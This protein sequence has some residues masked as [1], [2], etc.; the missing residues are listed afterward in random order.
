MS[1][2]VKINI[3]S[4]ED[5]GAQRRAFGRTTPEYPQLFAELFHAAGTPQTA[6]FDAKHGE[7]PQAKAGEKYVIT[8]SLSSAYDTDDWIAR[9]KNFVRTAFEVNAKIAG[10]CF[11]HQV[12]AEALGGHVER[13]KVGW[14]EGIRFSPSTSEYISKKFPDGGFWLDYNHHDQVLKLPDGAERLSGSEFCPIESYRIGNKVLCF[15]GH[16]EFTREYSDML[17]SYFKNEFPA[18]VQAA[19]EATKNRETDRLKIGKIIAEF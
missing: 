17:F 4:C 3:I 12:V 16:P 7:L 1:C 18:P 11:G 14:G 19:R 2:P 15:Q 10:I 13:A 5:F 8:G 6:V 9:L